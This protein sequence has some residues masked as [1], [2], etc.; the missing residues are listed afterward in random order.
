MDVFLIFVVGKQQRKGMPHIHVLMIFHDNHFTIFRRRKGTRWIYRIKEKEEFERSYHS[1]V[2]VQTVRK[3]KKGI[4][5]ITK[6]LSKYTAQSQTLTLALCWLF[7][8]RS[9]AVSGNFYET[10]YVVR[11][12]RKTFIQ[13]DLVGNTLKVKVEW[14]IFGIYSANFL[15]VNPSKWSSLIDLNNFEVYWDKQY[16]FARLVK[17]EDNKINRTNIP[18]LLIC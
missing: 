4:R 5:Y 16:K 8:K 13:I 7:K 1:F 11:K 12:F 15:G 9:F 6:Y 14:V 3:L 17:K 10:I 2:D 18:T